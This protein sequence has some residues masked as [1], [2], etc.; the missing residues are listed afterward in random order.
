[1]RKMNAAIVFLTYLFLPR[2]CNK[3]TKNKREI[4]NKLTDN[5]KR[6][7][8]WSKTKYLKIPKKVVDN[9]EAWCL[10]SFLRSHKSCLTNGCTGC[11]AF[12]LAFPGTFFGVVRHLFLGC[13]ATFLE[14]TMSICALKVNIVIP[15][16]Y[17]LGSRWSLGDEETASCWE[18]RKS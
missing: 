11:K 8:W 14:S 6:N 18:S 12:F 1:M 3:H 10:E 15:S 13:Q 17:K 9:Y 16:Y 4:R 7:A 5:P 2:L